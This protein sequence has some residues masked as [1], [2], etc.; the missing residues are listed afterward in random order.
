MPDYMY[1]LES[2]LSPEQRAAMLR[3]QELAAAV[4]SQSVSGRRRGARRDF[5][6][7]HPRSG[8]HGR[9][10]SHRII[11]ELEKGGAKVTKRRRIAAL[12]GTCPLRRGGRQHFRG[13]RGHLRASRRETRNTIFHHH[14]RSA[15]P[16]FLHQR[17]RDFPESEFARTAARSHERTRRP[18]TPRNSR[19][20][21]S[22]FYEPAG[23]PVARA[24]LCRA[25]GIQDGIAHQRNGSTWP[26]SANCKRR[27]QP[28]DAGSEFRQLAREEKPAL[29]LKA[30]ESHGLLGVV[31]PTLEKRH[32]DY[33]AIN[34]IFRVR[35][36]MVSSGLRPRLF[37]PV[38]VAIL[39]RLKDT[40]TKIR[41][42]PHGISGFGTARR[43]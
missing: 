41:A 3:I 38:T 19:V 9:R 14:G 25:H 18:G 22:Q 10:K 42:R 7:V 40:R 11:H 6:N 8:F 37:A 1:Q 35:E 17:H 4:R 31:N 2:R 23:A 36:D 33:D 16:R 32:P 13:A 43:Q 39:G 26:W 21:D 20:V 28:E 12:R 15:P 5:R 30:W 34:R 29:V 27:F 24:A